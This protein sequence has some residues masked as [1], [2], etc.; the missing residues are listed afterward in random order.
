MAITELKLKDILQTNFHN[1]KII[2][3]DYAGDQN[4]YSIEII[5][6]SFQGLSLIKQH[7]LVKNALSGILQKELHAVTIKTK[8]PEKE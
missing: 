3:K 2:I 8:T 6:K 1:D 4:H 7:R 5:S